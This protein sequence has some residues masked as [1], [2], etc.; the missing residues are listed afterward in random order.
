V[1]TSR[2][3]AP[4]RASRRRADTIG[5][6]AGTSTIRLWTQTAGVTE[7]TTPPAA[8]R[9]GGER[10]DTTAAVVTAGRDA[11]RPQLPR[12]LRRRRQGFPA[13]AAVPARASVHGRRRLRAAIGSLNR[14]GP[15][16]LMDAPLAAA[17]GT[18]LDI[19]GTTPRVVLD[20]GVHGSEAAVLAD[21]R[22]FDA[23]SC[24]V[25]CREIERAVRSYLYR[26][27]HLL[28]QPH[29]A[30]WAL[31]ST[32]DF[33]IGRDTRGD[34]GFKPD[35]L[36]AELH[37]PISA[38]VGAVRTASQRASLRMGKGVLDDGIVVVGGGAYLRPLREALR[39][40][41]ATAVISPPDPRH[42][43]IRGL[44]LFVAEANRY[45]RLWDT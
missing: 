8:I 33:D 4:R 23:V 17:A 7:L 14:G 21:G 22:V 24:A 6:D 1:T 2:G 29:A 11:I 26:R 44:A 15:V 45:P 3:G 28:D 27:H 30:W 34:I 38:V 19:T 20:V 40:E 32:A 10:S 31:R 43:V 5:I 9:P 25:G 12:S 16:L 39:D 18:D 41:L 36:A 13:V 37:Q 35:E 42:A